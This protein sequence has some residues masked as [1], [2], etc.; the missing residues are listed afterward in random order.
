MAVVGQDEV[1]LGKWM[2]PV[3]KVPGDEEYKD[4]QTKGILKGDSK[5]VW[6]K[7]S[8]TEVTVPK[9]AKNEGKTYWKTVLNGYKMI[10]SVVLN[11]DGTEAYVADTIM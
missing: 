9:D 2:D 10:K 11:K 6:A 4:D 7:Y 8:E 5:L 3:Y 1:L